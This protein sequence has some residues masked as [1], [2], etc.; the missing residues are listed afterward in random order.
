MSAKVQLFNVIRPLYF[1]S[2]ILSSPLYSEQRNTLRKKLV[3]IKFYSEAS[4]FLLQ[5]IGSAKFQKQE[6]SR[7]Y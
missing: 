4:C 6:S 7:L 1:P 5:M 2:I 3:K